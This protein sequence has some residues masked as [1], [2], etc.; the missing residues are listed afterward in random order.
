MNPI[1]SVENLSKQYRIGTKLPYKTLRETI[2]NAVTS[3]ARL[4]RH[5]GQRAKGKVLC[6]LLYALCRRRKTAT[7]GHWRMYHLKS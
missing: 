5:L 3:P 1:I 6:P 2:M 4:F 7:S